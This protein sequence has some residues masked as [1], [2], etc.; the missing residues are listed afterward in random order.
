[1]GDYD[2]ESKMNFS[3]SKYIRG[4]KCPKL[5]WLDGHLE[6]GL[7]SIDIP[8]ILKLH[9]KQFA[10]IANGLFPGFIEIP[11]DK[12]LSVAIESTKL[13]IAEGE[14]KISEASFAVNNLFCAVDM[15]VI[16]DDGVLIYE[17]KSATKVK[18]EYVDDVAFQ[19][20]VLSLCG[21]RVK[22]AF[23]VYV[24]NG[25]VRNGNID[26]KGFCVVEDVTTR[27]LDI[28]DDVPVRIVGLSDYVSVVDEPCVDSNCFGKAC[29]YFSNCFKDLTNGEDIFDIA[30]MGNKVKLGL[31]FTGAKGM[32]EVLEAGVKLTGRQRIQVECVCNEVVEVIDR[33][34]LL[35]HVSKYRFPIYF[36]DFE[37]YQ[38]L[39]P[40]FGNRPYQQVPSQFSIHKLDSLGDVL[41]EAKTFSMEDLSH[42]EFLAELGRDPRLQVASML[43]EMIPPN[44]GVVVAYNMSFEKG[45]ISNLIKDVGLFAQMHP[46][47]GTYLTD[48]IA[49]LERINRQFVDLMEPF[50]NIAFYDRSMGGSYSI[51]K[52]LPALCGDDPEL[53]YSL[54]PGVHNGSEAMW[55]Y[56]LMNEGLV[57][58]DE[59]EETRAGLLAYCRLDT[60]AMV[61][62][63]GRLVY[64]SRFGSL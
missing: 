4:L 47:H 9:G 63:F 50:K 8:E 3:K 27:V 51:K 20:H 43:V 44:N 53:D 2:K 48:I 11:Y 34:A 60:W 12:D 14:K 6:E 52:V 13:R 54:L 18:D 36:L 17:M 49:G 61:K 40:L 45:V 46:G 10:D 19:W 1:V 37:T 32:C 7:R 23:V 59:I 39:V 57:P 5:L 30:G 15:L 42:R 56:E 62:I 24:N 33:E 31:Y 41:Q 38:P 22:G 58:E 26:P 55:I 25:Y 64:E 21:Y 16:E 29:E 28:V 35:E